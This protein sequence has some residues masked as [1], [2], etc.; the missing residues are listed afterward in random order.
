MPAQR[1]NK[2]ID[3]RNRNWRIFRLRGMWHNHKLLDE[4]FASQ[5]KNAIDEQLRELGAD[6]E[7]QRQEDSWQRFRE[8]SRHG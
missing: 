7:T 6:P 1:T 4:P 5:F 8:D 3:A 2:Q